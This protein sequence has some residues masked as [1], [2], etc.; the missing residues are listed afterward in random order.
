M[1]IYSHTA[2]LYRI[3]PVIKTGFSLRSFLYSEKPLVMKK[4][5]SLKE[6][7]AGKQRNWVGGVS[8]MSIIADIYY[9]LC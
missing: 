6:N 7:F 5:F 8:Q 9:D 4:G 3:K 1:K 2:N